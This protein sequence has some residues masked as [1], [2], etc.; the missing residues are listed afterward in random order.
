MVSFGRVPAAILMRVAVTFIQI[1]SNLFLMIMLPF[2]SMSY[3]FETVSLSKECILVHFSIAS[4]SIAAL[5]TTEP[6]QQSLNPLNC[7]LSLRFWFIF[8]LLFCSGDKGV[9]GKIILKCI[10]IMSYFY[11]L[12]VTTFPFKQCLYT[13]DLYQGEISRVKELVF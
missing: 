4:H 6:S 12:R 8:Y 7:A 9:E 2:Y 5:K 11:A 10:D 3:I 1:L 13:G